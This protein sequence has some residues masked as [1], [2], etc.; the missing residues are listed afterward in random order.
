V[1]VAGGKSRLVP[2]HDERDTGIGPCLLRD[3][4]RGLVDPR[5]LVDQ[6]QSPPAQVDAAVGQ[7]LLAEVPGEARAAAGVVLVVAGHGNVMSLN[8]PHVGS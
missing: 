2:H 8:A 3:E 6:D 5:V 4:T 1:F 7:R